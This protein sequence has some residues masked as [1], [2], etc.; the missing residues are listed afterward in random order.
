MRF[1]VVLACLIGVACSSQ[2][3]ELQPGFVQLSPPDTLVDLSS[4]YREI[5]DAIGK[6][7]GAVGEFASVRWYWHPTEDH[8]ITVDG[9]VVAAMATISTYTIRLGRTSASNRLVVGHEI[10]HLRLRTGAHPVDQ[11]EGKCNA[12]VSH[13]YLQH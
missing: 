11:F 7:S 10:L 4:S 5:W 13:G 6:C 1:A 9:Q 12:L 3:T 2:V 8:P